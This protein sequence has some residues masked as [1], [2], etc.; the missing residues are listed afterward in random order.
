MLCNICCCC[1]GRNILISTRNDLKN[2]LHI[3]NSVTGTIARNFSKLRVPIMIFCCAAASPTLVIS[4]S[5]SRATSLWPIDNYVYSIYISSLQALF[6][7][8]DSFFFSL[9]WARGFGRIIPLQLYCI[10]YHCWWIFD[11]IGW[12]KT[13]RVMWEERNCGVISINKVIH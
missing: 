3:H 2:G 12:R 10:R 9:V 8:R 4:E 5:S 7:P 13:N 1:Q 6:Y 11:F